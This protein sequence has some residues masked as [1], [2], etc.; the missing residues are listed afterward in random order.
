MA[1]RTVAPTVLTT[2]DTLF[3]DV[4]ISATDEDGVPVDLS[5]DQVAL[6]FLPP[7]QIPT[8]GDW[9]AA[10]WNAAATKA[11]VLVGPGPGGVIYPPGRYVAWWTVTDN[12]EVPARPTVGGLT[13][14]E[15]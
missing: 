15:T 2:S 4:P 8:E 6:A 3:V 12:P 10:T 9:L 13:V 1:A 11:S 14:K 5:R 7:G